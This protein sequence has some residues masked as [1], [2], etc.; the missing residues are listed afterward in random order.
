M[1]GDAFTGYQ[2]HKIMS[3][4]CIAIWPKAYSANGALGHAA[5]MLFVGLNIGAKLKA[6]VFCVADFLAKKKISWRVNRRNA[7]LMREGI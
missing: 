2:I 7:V 3:A 1:A 4:L 5:V 6:H